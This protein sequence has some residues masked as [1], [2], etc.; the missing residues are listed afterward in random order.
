[1]SYDPI[2]ETDSVDELI[3]EY[4]MSERGDVEYS[5]EVVQVEL[6]EAL[7]QI[8]PQTM[9]DTKKLNAV[10]SIV[11]ALAVLRN[12]GANGNHFDVEQLVHKP[13]IPSTES[14]RHSKVV[15][16]KNGT[17]LESVIQI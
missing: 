14:D 8:G 7:N 2:A 13:G 12:E 17:P 5:K 6:L 9:D 10:W 15:L 16:N 3:E 11:R 4:G 1:M